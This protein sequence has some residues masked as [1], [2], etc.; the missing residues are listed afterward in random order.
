MIKQ[1]GIGPRI[2]QQLIVQE[3]VLAEADRLGSPSAT[4][5]CASGCSAIRRFRRT[6]SSIGEARYRQMH[7]GARPPIKP[8][9]FEDE[10]RRTLTAEKLD[11][12]LAAGSA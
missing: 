1:L 11:T 2:V 7:D 6:D 9:E 5:N 3:A 8:A 10:L 4:A 12:A